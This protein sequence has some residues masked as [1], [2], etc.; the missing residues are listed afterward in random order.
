M[1]SEEQ[2][3]QLKKNG[4]LVLATL[5]F[6]IFIIVMIV[7]FSKSKPE[8]ISMGKQRFASVRSENYASVTEPS[9]HEGYKQGL[10]GVDYTGGQYVFESKYGPGRVVETSRP[11]EHTEG[12]LSSVTEGLNLIDDRYA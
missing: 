6:T 10:S 3:T 9:K 8:P 4:P 5:L 7:L 1:L 11:M 2:K 12:L